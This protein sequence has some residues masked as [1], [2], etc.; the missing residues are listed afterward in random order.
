MPV[1][2]SFN[3]KGDIE[4]NLPPLP[5]F[6]PQNGFKCFY[7]FAIKMAKSQF[8]RFVHTFHF[9]PKMFSSPPPPPQLP[10]NFDA[11]AATA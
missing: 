1:S 9:Q 3:G 10:Q 5:K 7:N 6:D 4:E 11:G 8:A 2:K